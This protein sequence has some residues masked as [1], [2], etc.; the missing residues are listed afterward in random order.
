MVSVNAKPEI[1]VLSGAADAPPAEA[2]T[3]TF[4]G[5]FPTGTVVTT[6][7]VSRLTTER[8]LEHDNV[9]HRRGWFGFMKGAGNR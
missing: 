5:A 7:S 8:S 1:S 4:R 2:W 9:L 6:E 3:T